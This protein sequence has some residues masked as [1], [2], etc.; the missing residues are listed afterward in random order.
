ML[1]DQRGAG[2]LPLKKTKH[3]SCWSDEARDRRT[4]SAGHLKRQ[5][6]T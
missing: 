2:T 4:T 6:L 5:V 3:A 1:G